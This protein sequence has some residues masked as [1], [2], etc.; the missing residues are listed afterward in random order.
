MLNNNSRYTLLNKF[1]FLEKKQVIENITYSDIEIK[2]ISGTRKQQN[3]NENID[4]NSIYEFSLFEYLNNNDI[5][6]INNGTRINICCY[7]INYINDVPYYKYLLY[8]YPDQKYFYSNVLIFPFFMNK[9]ND[10]LDNITTLIENIDIINS[11][12]YSG[13]IEYNS[14]IYLFYDCKFKEKYINTSNSLYWLVLASDIINNNMY[15]N[16]KIHNSASDF[17]INNYEITNIKKNNFVIE[18]PLTLY[19]GIKDDLIVESYI[20]SQLYSEISHVDKNKYNLIVSFTCFTKKINII[21]KI[22]LN[23]DKLYFNNLLNT[24]KNNGYDSLYILNSKNI[25][26]WYIDNKNIIIN[27]FLKI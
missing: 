2:Y 25:I 20:N 18:Y 27:C 12:T 6:N 16:Y 23:N 8:K 1:G 24:I 4:K 15:Y 10:I 3:V 14:E 13:Y 17:F 26:T 19:K 5:V 22:D 11:Q 21:N 7:S 9:N